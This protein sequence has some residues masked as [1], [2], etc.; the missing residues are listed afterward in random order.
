MVSP[1]RILEVF[2]LLL[3]AKSSKRVKM[4]E[5]IHILKANLLIIGIGALAGYTVY[6]AIYR[7]F[8]SPIAGFPGPKLA[9]LTLWYRE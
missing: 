8:L 5:V 6:G 9:A 4:E 1:K 3:A 2:F 7:L